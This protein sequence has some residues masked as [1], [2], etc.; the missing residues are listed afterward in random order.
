MATDRGIDLENLIEIDVTSPDTT[1]DAGIGVADP[2]AVIIEME[3]GSVEVDFD[4]EGTEEGLSNVPHNANLAEFMDEDDLRTLG[5]DLMAEIESDVQSRSEW[6][7]MYVKGLEVLGFNYEERTEPWDGACGVYSNVLAEAAIRFQAETMV[8]TFPA[9]GP[10]K[11]KVIG[12][13]TREKLEAA[14]RVRADMNHELLEV[15]TEYRPE[16]E[17]M[18]FNLGLAG[19]AFKKVY[20]CP[21]RGRQTAMYV[22]AEEMIV[23]YGASDLETCTR[24]TH[25]MRKTEGDIRNLVYSG[26]YKECELS[27][28]TAFKTDIEEAKAELAGIEINEDNRYALYE[29]H[30]DLDLESE[31]EMSPLK[32][33]VVTIE[34]DSG[35]VLAV[36]RNWEENAQKPRKKSFFVHYNYVPATG[37]Y[38]LGL[39]HIIGGYA[40]AGTSL[41]RQLVDSGTLSNLPGGL[42]TRGMRVKG[43]DTPISPGEFRDVDVPGGTLKENIMPLPYKEP[44]QVLLALLERIT[45]E[46][47]RL[48]AISDSNVSDMSNEAPVGTTL[49]LLERTLKPMAAVQARLHYSMKQEFKLLKDL[50]AEYGTPLYDYRPDGAE[51]EQ[52]RSDYAMTS[53]LPVSDP[54]NTTMAQRIATYQAALQMSQNAPQIYNLP[55]LHRQMLDVLG[56]KDTDK[57]VPL[58]DDIKPTDPVSENMAALTGEPIKAFIYQDHDAHIKAHVSFMK[59]PAIAQMVGQNPQAQGIMASL[60]AHIAEHMAFKYRAEIED[61]LGVELPA[62]QEELPEEIEIQLSRLVADAGEQLTQNKQ[63]MA[64]MAAAQQV[65]QDPMFQLKQM[66]EQ[67]KRMEVQRKAKAD[68]MEQELERAENERKAMVEMIEKFI[69]M[70]ELQME[71]KRLGIEATKIDS[72]TER[73]AAEFMLKLRG[74]LQQ[75]GNNSGG[76]NE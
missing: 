69:E 75:G 7:Q 55:H 44:S 38:G 6:V 34:R 3:D 76:N 20:Y 18:L 74:Q 25:L 68:Q 15:M 12:E 19:S 73:Q 65:Q 47:R 11:T 49:A 37:F 57:V 31:D 52:R 32:P 33:Y 71:Q 13:E 26:F 53:V 45:D 60:Q 61:K 30:V 23:P 10:V 9:A 70:Q 8:E 48:A 40:R 5:G 58:E 16:H 56:V 63:K 27:E 39:I 50:I 41:L 14:E 72:E 66:A 36:Y 43:D 59:D 29:C 62:P 51:R 42:K 46:G 21:I 4:P 24:A 22:P 35:E 64:A 67:T 17:K 54:N 2:D 1:L 28:P